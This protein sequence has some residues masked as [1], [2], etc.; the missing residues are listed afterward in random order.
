MRIDEYIA[1]EPTEY[2][3]AAINACRDIG[4]TTE[5]LEAG[6]L[7]DLLEIAID[8]AVGGINTQTIAKRVL[9]KLG[10]KEG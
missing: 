9:A 3:V 8:S 2:V 5:A 4:A 1:A 6:V 7:Q 10:A